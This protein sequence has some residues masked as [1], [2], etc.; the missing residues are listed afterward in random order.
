MQTEHDLK[1]EQ[2]RLPSV[3]DALPSKQYVANTKTVCKATDTD[4]F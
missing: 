4:H 2:N 1:Q 3:A